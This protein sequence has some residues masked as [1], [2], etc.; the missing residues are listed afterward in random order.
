MQYLDELKKIKGGGTTG[1]LKPFLKLLQ[2]YL[3]RL[4]IEKASEVVLVGDGAPWIW[5][6]IPKL[7]K[8]TGVD[9]QEITEIID[10]THAKQNLNKAF[11]TLSKKISKKL[12]WTTSKIF[13]FRAMSQ[14]SRMKSSRF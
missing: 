3:T 13:C 11:G 7:L 1:N 2:H 14:E 6:R 8:D 12:I 5:E 9:S 10:W 4:G